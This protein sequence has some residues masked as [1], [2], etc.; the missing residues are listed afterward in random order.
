MHVQLSPGSSTQQ[1][2]KQQKPKV[3]NDVCCSLQLRLLPLLLLPALLCADLE[4]RMRAT[5]GALASFNEDER[6]LLLR[7]NTIC[8]AHLQACTLHW[9]A[10]SSTARIASASACRA[11]CSE[12]DRCCCSAGCYRQHLQQQQQLCR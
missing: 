5:L 7:Y 9:A 10:M 6:M 12:D 4:Q 2:G 11:S 8:I 1:A 3:S